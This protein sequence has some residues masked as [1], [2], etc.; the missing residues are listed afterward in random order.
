MGHNPHTA[1]HLHGKPS[2]WL[3]RW[4]HLLAPGT[5]VLDLAC[6]SGRHL[7]WLVE[8]GFKATGVD[9]DA[10]ALASAPAGCERVQADIESG[11]WPLA[12]RQ[13]GGVLQF[14]Y[15]WRPLWPHILG[16]LAPGGVL[17]VETFADG[18]QTVGRPSRPD[19]LLQPG[20]LLQVCAGLRVVAYEDGY[21]E[22][23]ER[24]VQRV[25][26]VRPLPATAL[27]PRHRLMPSAG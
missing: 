6:G 16:A 11:P 17:I 26:A 8:R 1:M 9:R 20:E 21:L 22:D 27:P 13:F 5:T 19:F 23:P 2:P 3:E 14:N 25:V 15:L 24:F 12:E 4:G 7:H 10:Q 18:N